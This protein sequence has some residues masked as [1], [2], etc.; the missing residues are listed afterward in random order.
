LVPSTSTTHVGVPIQQTQTQPNLVTNPILINQHLGWSELV[1]PL[2]T[3]QLRIVSYMMWYNTIPS[4][5]PMDPNMYSMYYLGIKGLDPLT[6]GR[7]KGYATSV[8]QP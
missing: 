7:K 6:F 4:F 1:T 8:T 5:V 3:W 2:I